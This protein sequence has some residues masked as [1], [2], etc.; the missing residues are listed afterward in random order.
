MRFR[1]TVLLLIVALVA[2]AA[3]A[4]GEAAGS[5]KTTVMIYM[6]G[7]DLE[8]KNFQGTSTMRD[9][10]GSGINKEQVNV[11]ALLGGTTVW[12]R[13]YDVSKLTLVEL[14]GRRAVEVDSFEGRSMGDPE[15][16]TTF[17]DMCRERYPAERYILIMWDHGGG[18]NGGVCFDLLY[19]D[20]TLSILELASALEDSV[21]AGKGLDIIAFNTCL[22][23]S[24]EFA[25]NLAPFARYMVATE[26]SMY[27]LDY[28]WLKTADT[29]ETPLITAQHI[30][31]GTYALNKQIIA[32]QKALEM[33]SVAKYHLSSR[34]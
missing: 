17:L 28:S 5:K 15:T 22:T 12:G 30:V 24:I 6:C 21:F 23:G 18:P 2:I 9:I 16:L 3:V 34:P 26:D 31:D 13:G 11:V 33:N 27:G 25:A 8:A 4:G 19:N 20:D 14:G 32:S 1:I 29:D 7:A 10:N